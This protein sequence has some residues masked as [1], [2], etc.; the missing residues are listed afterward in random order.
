VIRKSE[1]VALFLSSNIG[2]S[3]SNGIFVDKK[4]EI[5]SPGHLSQK[6]VICKTLT[7]PSPHYFRDLGLYN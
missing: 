4:T 3:K 7:D 5:I 6:G 2:A 1:F